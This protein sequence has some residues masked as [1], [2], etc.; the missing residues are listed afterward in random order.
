MWKATALLMVVGG[1][2]LGIL[3]AHAQQATV[4]PPPSPP[5]A[6]DAQ[7]FATGWPALRQRL[8]AADFAQREAAQEEL[9][10]LPYTLFPEVERRM[11]AE[12]DPEIRVRLQKGLDAL[13]LEHLVH[14]QPVSVDF[15]NAPLEV[16]VGQ[17]N[18]FN[19]STLDGVL[20][21]FK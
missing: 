1:L 15:D 2:A 5:A 20:N 10:K 8:G 19:T 17:L 21:M 3:H 9:A 7:R 6:L 12:T 16:V 13:A 18:V 14:Q 11:T 4:T